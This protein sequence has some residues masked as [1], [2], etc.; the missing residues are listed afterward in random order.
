MNE[1]KISVLFFV[2]WSNGKNVDEA[3]KNVNETNIIKKRQTILLLP[4]AT[5]HLIPFKA[6]LHQHSYFKMNRSRLNKHII[7][8][9]A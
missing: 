3:K 4:A 1:N 7:V 5:K 6:K 2:P 9:I 8:S